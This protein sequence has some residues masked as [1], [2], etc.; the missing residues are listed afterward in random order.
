[1]SEGGRK[2]GREREERMKG[3]RREGERGR[4]R[5]RERGRERE[6]E[7][8]WEREREKGRKGEREREDSERK[9]K[10]C[11]DPYKRSKTVKKDVN[12]VTSCKHH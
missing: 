4:E 11:S 2:W 7:R 10:V 3:R 8:E 12:S 5:E 6:R 9:M 1:M